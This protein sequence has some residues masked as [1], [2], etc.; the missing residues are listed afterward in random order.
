MSRMHAG[1]RPRSHPRL[2]LQ[3]ART[4]PASGVP[5]SHR[6][7]NLISKGL[8]KYWLALFFLYSLHLTTCEM[9]Q[10]VEEPDQSLCGTK[11]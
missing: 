2:V 10:P 4:H 5:S 9:P 3:N 1:S 7:Q 8:V 11:F 6:T